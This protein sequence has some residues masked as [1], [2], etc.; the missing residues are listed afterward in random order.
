MKTKTRKTPLMTAETFG[1][2]SCPSGLVP[3]SML[4]HNPKAQYSF[5]LKLSRH[6]GKNSKNRCANLCVG[7]K[8]NVFLVFSFRLLE[9]G[10]CFH[11]VQQ[12]RQVNLDAMKHEGKTN[13][14]NPSTTERGF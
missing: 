6:R 9:A 10:G 12:R 2:T 14:C 5:M 3:K 8:K 1:L 7:Y 13:G 11:F 4:L